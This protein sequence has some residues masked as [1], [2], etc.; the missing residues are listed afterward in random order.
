MG[1]AEQ[2]RRWPAVAIVA[3]MVSQADAQSPRRPALGNFFA[4]LRTALG[5]PQTPHPAVVRVIAPE[6]DGVGYGSG[7]LV[8]VNATH[9]LIVTN[10]H[11]VADAAGPITVAFP[12]GFTSP[13]QVL[14]M[15]RDW[16]LAA[17]AIRR[18]NVSP[19]RLARQPPRP[20]D[21]LTIA[22]YGSGTYRQATGRCTQYVAPGTNL[23]YEMVELSAAARQGDS[24][25]PIFNEQGELAGVLFG[26][27]GGYTSGSYH[28]RVHAFLMSMSADLARAAPAPAAIPTTLPPDA[29]LLTASPSIQPPDEPAA[30]LPPLAPA[31][32][33][34][35]APQ[36][37]VRHEPW[38]AVGAQRAV[39]GG[40]PAP[41]STGSESLDWR[42][43]LG[44]SPWDQAKSAFAL[45]GL[46][47]LLLHGAR[48]LATGG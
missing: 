2:V 13:A 36:C 29:H 40:D 16:D 11:V 5:Q 9:G 15:D 38:I 46:L 30:T 18:P 28:G 48:W 12:D 21:F 1:G 31:D 35:P 37:A 6:R 22:G 3:L 33:E 32:D 47:A 27:G 44:C 25:G 45:V 42:E 19:V 41:G 20:G 24:G 39:G 8:D 43:L 7:T 14:K 4:D 23:P 17:L 34:S 26:E 10:W